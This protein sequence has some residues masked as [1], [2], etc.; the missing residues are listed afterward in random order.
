MCWILIQLI[1]RVCVC[2]CEVNVT[3]Y[4]TEFSLPH[5]CLYKNRTFAYYTFAEIED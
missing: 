2:V 5:K 4:D 3:M 1:K